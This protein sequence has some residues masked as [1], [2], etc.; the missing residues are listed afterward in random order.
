MPVPSPG[1]VWLVDL[2]PTRGHEQGGRR[3]CLVI[4]A[5]PFNHGPADLVIVLPITTRDRG[6]PSHVRVDPPEAGLRLPSFVKCEEVRSI[7]KDRLSTR[8][9]VISPATLAQVE[10]RLRLLLVL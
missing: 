10:D 3:P 5:D 2:D 1:E 4:S 9:G 7:S 8:W 6:I